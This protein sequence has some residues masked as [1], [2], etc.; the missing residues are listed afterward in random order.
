MVSTKVP[1][2]TS[3][4]GTTTYH[5][6]VFHRDAVALAYKRELTLEQER[7]IASR[8]MKIMAT[9]RFGAEVILPSAVVKVITA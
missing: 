7:D 8:I 4:D 3:S 2:G 9:H 1:T 6:F 5:A